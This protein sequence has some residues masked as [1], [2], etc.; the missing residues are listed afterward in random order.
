MSFAPRIV[1][2]Y[3]SLAP[4]N[5]EFY[6]Y[7]S[8]MRGP[9]VNKPLV[10]VPE[11]TPE[12]C[13]ANATLLSSGRR[14]LFTTRSVGGSPANRPTMVDVVTVQ[15]SG[16]MGLIN[17]QSPNFTPFVPL[18]AAQLSEMNAMNQAAVAPLIGA[19][20]AAPLSHSF[21]PAVAHA[22]TSGPAKEAPVNLRGSLGN[23]S[24]SPRM[25][26]F[27]RRGGMDR[28]SN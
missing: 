25:G 6:T 24:V 15:E 19:E 13:P 14:I 3:T 20:A 11:A 2:T 22:L 28:S 1:G 10:V 8:N 5:T 17:L 26:K 23:M 21:A 16:L 9:V 27:N 12:N 7:T 4:F 18:D